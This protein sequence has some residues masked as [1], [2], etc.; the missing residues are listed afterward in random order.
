MKAS[1]IL[2]KA[3]ELIEQPDRWAKGSMVGKC[4]CSGSAVDEAGRRFWRARN[5]AMSIL[6]RSIGVVSLTDLIAWNDAP[7][8]THPE[9]L[10]AFD[11]AITL[12][13]KEEA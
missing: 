12:A 6:R 5:N 11:S 1:E 10:A 2:I 8:R 9:V 7:E 3:R 13:Q 4:M